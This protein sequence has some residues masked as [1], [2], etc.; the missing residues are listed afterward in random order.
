MVFCRL[1][2]MSIRRKLIIVAVNI[3]VLTNFLE[4]MRCVYRTAPV[5]RSYLTKINVTIFEDI[6]SIKPLLKL[7]YITPEQ[8]ATESCR[9][10]LQS[11]HR[12]SKLP[13]FV[14]DEAHCV[15]SWGHDFRPDYLKLSRLRKLIPSVI[16]FF[17]KYS[18]AYDTMICWIENL[19]KAIFL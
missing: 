9:D 11:L 4:M 2:G 13:F 19:T 3:F 5:N 16:Y 10:L 8:A 6:R 17:Y 18:L 12:R 15:S 1:T 14:V 7:L